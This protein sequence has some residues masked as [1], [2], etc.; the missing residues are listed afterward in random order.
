V[1]YLIVNADDFGASHGV[2]RGILEAHLR[3]ILTSASLMVNAPASEE[4]AMLSRAVPGLS[5]GLHA[6]LETK[7]RDLRAQAD[8]GLAE[9]LREQFRRFEELMGRAPTHL[10]SH[11]N[12]HRHHRARPFFLDL[13]QRHG[14][15]LR[16]HSPVR[17]FSKFYGQWGGATHLEHISAESLARMLKT[18]IV[19][20]IT[21]LSCHPGYVDPDHRG[22]YRAEREAELRA[23]C[24]PLLR[25]VLLEQGIELISYHELGNLLASQPA[26][27]K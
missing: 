23:L 19:E 14:L 25:R 26:V 5:V 6:D 16:E 10:D 8:Q 4:A 9:G 18:E 17:Y 13:A 2:N 21:E 7:L 3:G 24:D 20:G 27:V 15:P 1:K 11:H 22:S 12:V